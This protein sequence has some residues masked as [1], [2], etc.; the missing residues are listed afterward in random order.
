MSLDFF[1]PLKRKLSI[2]SDLRK[3]L[4]K[5]PVSNDLA[6]KLDEEAVKESMKNLI[7]TNKGE[8]LFQPNLGSDVVKTLFDNMTPATLKVLETNVRTTLRNYEP[9]ATILDVEL[10]PYYDENRIKINIT[11]YVRS[12]EIP[13]TIAVFLERT[14]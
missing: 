13:I 14:R 8:R 4:E 11:F 9:R 5:N 10:I 3:D 1:T 6:L 12:A 7:L 2:Y